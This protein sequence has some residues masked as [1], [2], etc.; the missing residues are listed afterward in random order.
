MDKI[1]D[2]TP[3]SY[4]KTVEETKQSTGKISELARPTDNCS[5]YAV[6]VFKNQGEEFCRFCTD[7]GLTT[8]VPMEMKP[9]LDNKEKVHQKLV[10]VIRNLVFLKKD[11]EEKEIKTILETGILPIRVLCKQEDKT[12]F[13][14]IPATQMHEFQL[15][16]DPEITMHKYLTEQEAK[17][18]KGTPVRVKYGLL[19]GLTGKLV[20]SDKKY[21][22]L[23]EVPG[24][25]VML[26]VSRWCC[27][28]INES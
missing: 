21:Y 13:Y 11:R 18:K 1:N 16:C 26:K 9:Y 17:L 24:I 19:K 7:N 6:Y 25:G 15:M 10:P 28:K 3:C 5:W 20:R 14:I 4:S 2:T 23:K 8:F 12:V 22:L 27:E